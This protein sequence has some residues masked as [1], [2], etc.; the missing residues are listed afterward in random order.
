ML[1]ICKGCGVKAGEE[2]KEDCGFRNIRQES[3]ERPQIDPNHYQVGGSHYGGVTFQHWDFVIANHLGYFE[4]QITKYVLRWRKKNGK[5]DLQK[6]LHYL[7]KLQQALATRQLRW[8][9]S[10]K[11][12]CIP[13]LIIYYKVD[14]VEE[15]ICD[16]MCTYINNAQLEQARTCIQDLMEKS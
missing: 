1:I 16:L 5:Q 7:Q 9:V 14:A 12:R 6:A 4:G 3:N 13:E 10:R 15:M 2:H 8:P 11:A